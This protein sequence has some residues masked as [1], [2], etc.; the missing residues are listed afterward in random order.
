MNEPIVSKQIYGRKED[1]RVSS[2]NPSDPDSEDSSVGS[3]DEESVETETSPLP[4]VRPT[5]P[6]DAIRY[7]TIKALWRPLR[8][9][10]SKDEI[11]E[12][13]IDFSNIAKAF[14][15]EWTAVENDEAQKK[16]PAETIQARYAQQRKQLTSSLRAA[17]EHGH[18]F[19]LEKYVCFSPICHNLTLPYYCQSVPFHLRCSGPCISC[20]K[21]AGTVSGAVDKGTLPLVRVVPFDP[22]VQAWEVRRTIVPS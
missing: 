5:D 9:G 10:L 13:L 18:T 20:L 3:S 16:V 22:D 21:F 15:E 6:V 2:E 17:I 11:A 7:D 12:G 8:K 1:A 14:R 4:T 19:V